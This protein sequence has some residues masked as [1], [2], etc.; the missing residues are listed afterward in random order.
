MSSCIECR[1]A[2]LLSSPA[3][4]GKTHLIHHMAS[5]MY[6]SEPANNRVLTIAAADTSLDAKALLGNY[7]SSQVKP[8]TFEWQEGAI[9][10]AVRQGLWVVVEDI[11]RASQEIQSLFSGLADEMGPS[12]SLGARPSLTI[13]GRTS[14]ESGADFALFATR[15]VSSEAEARNPFFIGHHYYTNVWLP[16]PSAVDISRMLRAKFPRLGPAIADKLIETY[17]RLTSSHSGRRSRQQKR[18][19][20]FGLRDLDKW[21]ARVE[22]I[23]TTQSAQ[24]GNLLANPVVQDEI[25]LE[26]MDV[27]LASLN[28]SAT[29]AE[30]LPLEGTIVAIVAQALHLGVERSNFLLQKRTPLLEVESNSRSRAGNEL[31]VGRCH[32][33]GSPRD[34]VAKDNGRSSFALTRPSLTLLERLAAGVQMAEA[35]LLVGET[36]TGKTTVV[37]YLADILRK[38][39]TV[40]NLSTQTETSDLL[41]GFKPVDPNLPGRDL[42][43]RWLALFRRSFNKARNDKYET[44]VR[45][46]IQTGGWPRAAKMWLAS[47]ELACKRLREDI[48]RRVFGRRRRGLRSLTPCFYRSTVGNQ[49][50][51]SAD[52]QKRRKVGDSSNSSDSLQAWDSFCRDVDSFL[53]LSA[54]KNNRLVFSFVEGPLVR[55]MRQGDW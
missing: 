36:G 52:T 44:G 43:R 21:C 51:E 32:L 42:H 18:G 1:S 55:A 2:I 17:L 48:E 46:A 5:R 9:T 12:K 47:A 14:V 29:S 38:P 23:L 13:P 41:G 6:P 53:K 30:L 24:N 50:D 20:G 33:A 25:F 40:L 4:A 31:R 34:H 15:T 49:R 3:F 16:S 35:V 19:R 27:F 54:T 22:Q 37:Q 11:D 39:L 45:K 10:K 26:G 8:G 7:V 28:A